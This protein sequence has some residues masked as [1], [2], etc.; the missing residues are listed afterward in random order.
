MDYAVI[1]FHECNNVLQ[2]SDLEV[3]D[4][5]EEEDY[6]RYVE[7]EGSEDEPDQDDGE[8]EE[9]TRQDQVSIT[10]VR[11]YKKS[12]LPSKDLE[13]FQ[14]DNDSSCEGETGEQEA[15]IASSSFST[16]NITRGKQSY[17]EV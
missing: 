14:D 5:E 15:A 16:A 4:E 1:S 2:E 13:T 10:Q 6:S 8:D 7:E 12:R 3:I 11:H 17:F 9:V